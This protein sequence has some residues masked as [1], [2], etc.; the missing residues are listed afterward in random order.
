M[1]FLVFLDGFKAL[2]IRGRDSLMFVDPKSPTQQMRRSRG[3]DD[4]ETSACSHGLNS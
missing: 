1:N 3:I 4:M 2:V